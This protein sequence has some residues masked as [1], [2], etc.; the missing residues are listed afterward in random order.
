MNNNDLADATPSTVNHDC[1]AG[2]RHGFVGARLKWV[3][4]VMTQGHQELP[5]C[6]QRHGRGCGVDMID[7]GRLVR[8]LRGSN[9]NVTGIG[10]AALHQILREAHHREHVIPDREPRHVIGHCL[11][12]RSRARSTA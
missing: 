11:A 3:R 7:A 6:Q 1:L 12:A 8:Q 2:E 5:C 9:P 4:R 10:I